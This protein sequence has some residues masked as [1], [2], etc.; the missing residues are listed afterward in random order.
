VYPSAP[1]STPPPTARLPL[2][3][4]RPEP[5]PGPGA[6]RF[7]ASNRQGQAL[8]LGLEGR[9]DDSEAGGRRV[10]RASF[11]VI[12]CRLLDRR[13]RGAD[14]VFWRI[15]ISL[16]LWAPRRTR[17]RRAS[18]RCRSRVGALE[19]QRVIAGWASPSGFR[20]RGGTLRRVKG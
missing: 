1:A 12:V 10:L 19:A 8:W 4:Q 20:V 15:Q 14:L 18:R 11:N 5:T 7:E 3:L 13:P 17:L 16:S 6:P 2:R 9:V